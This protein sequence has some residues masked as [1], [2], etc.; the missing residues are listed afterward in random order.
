MYSVKSK[1]GCCPI[2]YVC[3]LNLKGINTEVCV[4]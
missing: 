3:A 4:Q 1:W 2:I